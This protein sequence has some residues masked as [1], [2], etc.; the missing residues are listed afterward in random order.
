MRI[1]QNLVVLLD[2]IV[3]PLK[4][5]PNFEALFVENEPVQN[6]A[7]AL[8]CDLLEFLSR[9]LQYYARTSICSSSNDSS[10]ESRADCGSVSITTSFDKDLLE[11]SD[12]VRHHWTDLDIGSSAMTLEDGKKARETETMQRQCKLDPVSHKP[13]VFTHKV[14][15]RKDINRWLAPSNVNEDLR[16]HLSEYMDGSCKWLVEDPAFQDSLSGAE[17]SILSVVARPGGGKTT[18]AAF[19][20]RHLNETV[21]A[22]VLYFFCKNSSGQK[23]TTLHILRSLLWQL[24]QHDV[25]LYTTVAQ[26]FYQSEQS[27]AESASLMIQ[28]FG[29]CLQANTAPAAFIVID[30][31]DECLDSSD[32]LLAFTAAM[33]VSTRLVKLYLFSRDSVSVP[34]IPQLRS[35]TIYM[36]GDKSHLALDFYVKQRVAQLQAAGGSWQDP[37]VADSILD[38]SNVVWLSAKLL[39]DD[40]E[41]TAARADTQRPASGFPRGL[42]NLYSDLMVTKEKS[43]TENQLKMAQDLY[44]WLDKTEYMPEWLRWNGDDDIL[45]DETIC[46]IIDTNSSGKRPLN[47]TETVSLLASVLLEVQPISPNFV[48]DA[49]GVPYDCPIFTVQFSHQTAKQFLKWSLDAQLAELPLSLRPRRLASLYRGVA[50]VKYLSQN[51]DFRDCLKQLRERPKNGIFPTY[52]EIVYGLWDALRLSHLR[53]DLDA[54]EIAKASL[55]CDHLS[56]FLS[57]EKCLGWIEAVI[58]IN[59]AGRWNQL[60][61]NAEEV[62]EI[63]PDPRSPTPAFHRFHNARHTLMTDFSYILSSTWPRNEHLH[64][65][66]GSRANVPP[67]FQQRPL[68]RKIAVLARQYQWLLSPGYVRPTNGYLIDPQL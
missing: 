36:T 53:R 35:Q 38:A 27:I 5:Y 13:V 62:L 63:S 9:M 22:A 41:R 51:Q 68:A 25:G 59:Y 65:P 10:P 20:T 46:T 28:I 61:E 15:I 66:P 11:L 34:H 39:L 32:L 23:R 45:D 14:D 19:L 30:A 43:F 67:G 17:P 6:A 1:L 7:I 29:A 50:A 8:Y 48:V 58:I 60:I 26:W 31:L 56:S 18:A 44:L 52:L 57:T 47:P 24:L 42:K 55:L 33:M 37:H 4:R 64:S 54:D 49:H 3:D 16:K 40:L 12:N 2:R 21:S